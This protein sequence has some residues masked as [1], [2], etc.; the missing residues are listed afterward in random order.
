MSEMKDLGREQYKI[1]HDWPVTKLLINR[2]FPKLLSFYLAKHD[3]YLQDLDPVMKVGQNQK[4]KSFRPHFAVVRTLDMENVVQFIRENPE[5]QTHKIFKHGV[6]FDKL[7]D[8]YGLLANSVKNALSLRKN[9]VFYIKSLDREIRDTAYKMAVK[10]NEQE[11]FGCSFDYDEY[12]YVLEFK[13]YIRDNGRWA[14]VSI[15]YGEDMPNHWNMKLPQ[16]S[17]GSAKK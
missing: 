3:I 2:C 17:V 11:N 7:E 8:I 6:Y 16:S 5:F 14:V 15:M 13:K 12:D 4:D 10:F 1:E 9:K